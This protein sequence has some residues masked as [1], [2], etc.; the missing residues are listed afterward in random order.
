MN[1]IIEKIRAEIERRKD[2]CSGVFERNSDTYYQGK[3]VAYDEVLSFLSTLEE[4]KSND[5]WS[6]E[7]EEMLEYVIGDVNEAK[8][9]YTLRDAKKMADKEIAWLKSLR[10]Q[11]KED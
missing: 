5:K 6:A 2:I 11:K 10:P 8:Q 9:L 1:T 3:A 7:D 4:E